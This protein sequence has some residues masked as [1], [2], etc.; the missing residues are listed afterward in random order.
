MTWI[1][2]VS[3]IRNMGSM[4]ASDRLWMLWS[5]WLVE[6]V[7]VSLLTV[8]HYKK[9]KGFL[10]MQF[11]PFLNIWISAFTYIKL[12]FNF[13]YIHR[14]FSQKSDHMKGHFSWTRSTKESSE[15][16]HTTSLSGLQR[17]SLYITFFVIGL[18]IYNHYYSWVTRCCNVHKFLN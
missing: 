16:S 11:N 2:S 18:I 9:K 15:F 17:F 14:L 13:L 4:E 5:D 1:I 8:A 6:K 3:N 7:I 10:A 12:L